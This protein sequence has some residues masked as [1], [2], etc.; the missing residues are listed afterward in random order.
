[1]GPIK[2]GVIDITLKFICCEKMLHLNQRVSQRKIG[3]CIHAGSGDLK[4]FLNAQ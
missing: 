4:I 1:M 2:D 3:K